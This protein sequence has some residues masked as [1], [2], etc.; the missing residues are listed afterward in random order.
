MFR[1]CTDFLSIP[2]P[3]L[4]MAPN[5]KEGKQREQLASSMLAYMQ[6]EVFKVSEICPCLPISKQRFNESIR[7]MAS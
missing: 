4:V 1:K 7:G 3:L 6:P 2:Y 5:P